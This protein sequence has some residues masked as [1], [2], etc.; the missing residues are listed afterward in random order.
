MTGRRRRVA[1]L[2]AGMPEPDDVQA[3]LSRFTEEELKALLVAILRR[4]GHADPEGEAARRFAEIRTMS[5]EELLKLVRDGQDQDT[6]D[7]W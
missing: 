1:A 2:E 6:E 3:W 7:D 4:D 5:T